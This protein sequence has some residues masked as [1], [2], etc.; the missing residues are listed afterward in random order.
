MTLDAERKSSNV[1]PPVHVGAVGVITE[2]SKLPI[3]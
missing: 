3:D 2:R 1:V